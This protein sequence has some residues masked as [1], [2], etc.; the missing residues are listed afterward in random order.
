MQKGPPDLIDDKV[1]FQSINGELSFDTVNIKRY[2]IHE[3]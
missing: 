2:K 1:Q 3:K